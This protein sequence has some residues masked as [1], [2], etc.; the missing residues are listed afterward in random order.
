MKSGATVLLVEDDETFRGVLGRAFQRRGYRVSVATS[1]EEAIEIAGVMPPDYAARAE[2]AIIFT[3]A[4]WDAN[5]PQHI[6]QRID[7]EAVEKALRE[8]DRRIVEL[9]AEVARL[10]VK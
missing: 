4:A 6:P 5:C 7:A 3:V 8:R 2:Q 10:R 1:A 9:E